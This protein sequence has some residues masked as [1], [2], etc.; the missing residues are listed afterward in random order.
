MQYVVVIGKANKL[1]I[2]AVNVNMAATA[3]STRG[4]GRGTDSP[5]SGISTECAMVLKLLND[6]KYSCGL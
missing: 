5:S 2:R 4:V 1:P 3:Q 6:E